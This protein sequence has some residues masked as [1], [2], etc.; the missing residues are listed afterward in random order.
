MHEELINW[1]PIL[2]ALVAGFALGLAVSFA[3]RIIQSRTARQLAE[4]LFRESEERRNE[5]MEAVMGHIKASFGS[6]SLEA[7][8]RSTDEFLKLA[9]SRLD[10]DRAAGVK[11]LEAKKGLID[12]QLKRMGSEL[13]NVGRLVKELEK[14]RVEKFGDLTGQLKL[15]REQTADLA[16]TTN[17]L[18]EA[19]ASTKQRG[20]WG[21]RMAE[22]VLR[23]AGF[24]EGINYQKQKT[25][26]GESVAT[27]GSDWIDGMAPE[28]ARR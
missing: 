17:A 5:V 16:S 9:K 2:I 7:L 3:L 22:D 26:A 23:A 24:V 8:G 18:R 1:L 13:E 21:E 28:G 4:E 6:L 15:A 27:A 11:E 14:D 20:Q 19:L 25:M 12:E 10:S